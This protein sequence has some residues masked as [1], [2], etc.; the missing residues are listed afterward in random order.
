MIADI[1]IHRVAWMFIKRYGDDTAMRGDALLDKG[2]LD[3]TLV[4][5]AVIQAIERLQA[6]K[7][8]EGEAIN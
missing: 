8:L 4:W 7:P 6:T 2:D 3:G 5:L 1:D